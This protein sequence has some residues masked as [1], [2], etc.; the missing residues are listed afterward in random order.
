LNNWFSSVLKAQYEHSKFLRVPFIR[1]KKKT[2]FEQLTRGV[3]GAG[4][5][6]MDE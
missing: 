6:V 3:K 5:G 4:L 2:A 1:E